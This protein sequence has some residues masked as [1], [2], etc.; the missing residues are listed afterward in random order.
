[1]IKIQAQMNSWKI[2]AE[3]ATVSLSRLEKSYADLEKEWKAGE[4]E[5]S[6]LQDL[7]EDELEEFLD[8]TS[9][10]TAANRVVVPEVRIQSM[11]ITLLSY[12]YFLACTFTMY[13]VDN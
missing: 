5:L 7:E 2:Q 13:I 3:S 9:K 12:T 1:M 11:P 4:E 8:N 10:P 6:L